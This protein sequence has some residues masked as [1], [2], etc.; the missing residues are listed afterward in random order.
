M[1]GICGII[2]LTGEPAVACR[3]DAI[4]AALSHLGPDG[5]SIW[6]DGPASLG[7]QAMHSTSESLHDQLPHYQPE[8]GL[9]I[10]ADARLDNR[11]ELFQALAV[12]RA[13]RLDCGDGSLLLKAYEKWGEDCGKH[14]LGDFA[15][16]IWDV[17]NQTLFCCRDHMG[18]RQLV[19]YYDQKRFIFASEAKG[20]L[21]VPG[22]A[23][24]LNTER[25]AV[26]KMSGYFLVDNESTYYRN[27]SILPGSTSL[28]IDQRRLRKHKYWEPDASA[29]LPFKRDEEFLEAFRTLMFD[30]V[31]VRLRSNSPIA[32]M[33][34]GGLDSSAVVSIASKLLADQG[35]RLTTFSVV[36]PEEQRGK[37]EDERYFIDQFRPWSNIDLNYVT[38]PRRGPFDDLEELVAGYESPFL[39]SRHYNYSAI[40]AA[41]RGAGARVI[42]D[43]FLGELGP[44]YHGD[45]YYAELLVRLHWIRF[46]KELNNKRRVSGL[47]LKYDLFQH[48]IPAGLVQRWR[49]RS[50]ED[51]W[52]RDT[53]LREDFV[54]RELGELLPQLLRAGRKAKRTWPNL[55]RNHHRR[56]L[57]ISGK[58]RSL[59][60]FVGYEHVER[61]F[62]FLDKRLLEFCLAAP[63]RLKVR[64]GYQRYLIRAGLNHLLPPRIQWRTDKL[65]FSPDYQLRYNAQR[66]RAYSFLE[67]L[68]PGDPVRE[69]VDIDRLM[70]LAARDMASPRADSFPDQAAMQIVPLGVY[71]ITFLRQFNEFR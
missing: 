62:P 48:L 49:G 24:E 7:H 52:L 70:K 61:R 38:D 54:R 20:I 29:V 59:T 15:F 41:A 33:L 21:A 65:P 57:S 39:S 68:Q 36:A 45:G 28:T 44:T 23:K 10:T 35:Q 27:I 30:A 71:T 42:L 4:C 31:Q 67:S 19:Y 1:S 2:S 58:T 63:S 50:A 47:S 69:I 14:L 3:L 25:L 22:I 55:K 13:D 51:E 26:L 16:A 11:E 5:S 18:V 46:L 64:N 66:K 12:P 17:R 6:A 40:C 56:I 53:P 9:C 34:S 32:A 43:G 8:T 37:I 60:G